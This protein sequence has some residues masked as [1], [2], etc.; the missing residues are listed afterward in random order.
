M[1]V[2]LANSTCKV[3]GVSTFLL[4]LR[5][6]LAAA[7]HTCELFFFEGGT[8][9][10]HLPPDCPVQFGGLADLLRRVR[11]GR[12]D[13]V[14]A[15][16]IDWPTGISAVRRLGARLVLTA[17]TVREPAYTYGWHA[18][19]CDAFVAVSRWIRDGLRP[20][21]DA[22]IEVVYNGIDTS[23]FRP[24]PAQATSP[25]IAAW[26]GR[27]SAP[28]KRLGAFAAMAPH[29]RRRGFRIWVI[30]PQ[31]PDAFSATNPEAARVL[32]DAAEVWGGVPFA[33]MPRVYHQIAASGGCVIST[34]SMEGLPLTLLEAQACGCV[35]VAGDVL[36]VD[37]CVVPEGGGIRYPIDARPEEVAGLVVDTV[38]DRSAMQVRQAA[39]AEYVRARFSLSGMASRYLSLYERPSPSATGKG[40]RRQSLL[41]DWRGYR[42]E[43]LGV[44][45]EQYAASRALAQR[46]DL[47]LSRAAALDSIATAPTMYAAPRRLAHL[48]R[49]YLSPT[50]PNRHAPERR[51]MEGVGGSPDR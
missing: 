26:V 37:E 14:H 47:D 15:N 46:G 41:S 33:E 51:R 3:G 25:P 49:V 23:R 24:M 50:A 48:I 20:F 32:A 39:A 10:P 44:G 31:G 19:N 6:E 21:T 2:L 1:N 16:N 17:H 4:S 38:S 43:R 9:Q 42:D 30:D 7:G 27:G 29:L 18:G 34:A 28:R 22:P 8:M 11:D 36:G 13:I 12:I 35:V 5:D 40:R 45:Y